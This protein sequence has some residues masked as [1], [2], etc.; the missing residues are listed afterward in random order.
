YMPTVTMANPGQTILVRG[1]IPVLT[2]VPQIR[3]AVA[4]IDPL[5]AVSGT[6]TIDA[7]LGR[8]LAMP[9]FTML[10]L[11]CLGLTGLVLAV[12]GVYGV[13]S[14]FVTQ[15]TH[16]LGVRLALGASSGAVQSLVVRQGILLAAVGVLLGVALAAIAAR[17]LQNMVFGIS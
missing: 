14:Y 16:E 3:R 12:V 8:L 1:N 15:R 11:T 2:L 17:L 10:L 13:V 4:C 6:S 5:L 9:R 7:A